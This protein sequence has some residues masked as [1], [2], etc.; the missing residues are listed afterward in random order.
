MLLSATELLFVA[1]CG[2][3]AL[4]ILHYWIVLNV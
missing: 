2:G 1:E 3:F 4:H